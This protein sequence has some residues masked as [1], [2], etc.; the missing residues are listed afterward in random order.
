L[1]GWRCVGE[2]L[3]GWRGVGEVGR[4]W[5]MLMRWGGVGV[6]EGVGVGDPFQP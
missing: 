5:G 2:A 3:R 1:R 6:A 4:G